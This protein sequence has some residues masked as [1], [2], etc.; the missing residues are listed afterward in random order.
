M[1]IAIFGVGAL[2]GF[3][4]TGAV[5]TEGF[6]ITGS[7]CFFIGVI[8][9]PVSLRLNYRERVRIGPSGVEAMDER[10]TRRIVAWSTMETV[11]VVRHWGWRSIRVQLTDGR[12]LWLPIYVSQPEEYRQ[13]IEDYAGADHPL[14][15][16]LTFSHPDS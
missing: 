8:M 12:P 2:P 1:L 15:R 16:A 11:A 10:G 9:L 7:A 3:I 4:R 13:V 14:S 5:N 6:M